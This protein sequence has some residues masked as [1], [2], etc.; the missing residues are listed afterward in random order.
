METRCTVIMPLYNKEEYISQAIDSVIAQR[1][2]FPIKLVIADD[3]STDSSL[4]IAKKY[5]AE[6]P[7]LITVLESD[8]NR[9][10]L[11]NDIRVYE[12]M[13]TDY[14]CVLDP[15]DFWVDEQFIQKAV[16]FLDANKD[17]VCYSS[18]SILVEPGKEERAYIGA[19][20]KEYT[21]ASVYDYLYDNAIIPHTTGSVYRNSIF[22]KGVPDIIKNA[23]GTVSEASFRGDHDRF[24]IHLKYGKSYF[25]NEFVGVYRINSTGIWS[26]S[27]Q[28]HRDLLDVRA[29]MDYCAFY[30]NENEDKFREIARPYWRNVLL[31]TEEYKKRGIELDKQ[32]EEI[33]ESVKDWMEKQ[34]VV[35]FCIGSYQRKDT[36]LELVNH[37]LSCKRKDI[38]VVVVDNHSEDGLMDALSEIKD[39]R[40]RF[41]EHEATTNCKVTWYDAMAC[42]TG[43]WLFQVNDRD[44]I[45][46]DYMDKLIDTLSLFATTNVSFAVA[47]EEITDERDYSVYKEGKDTHAQFSLRDSHPTGQIIRKIYWDLCDD[48][49]KYYFE[50]E[51]GIYPHGYLY[52]ELGN[53][54]KGAYIHFD[55][56]DMANYDKRYAATSSSKVY[57]ASEKGTEWFMPSSRYN[58]LERAA[59]YSYLL[60]N[61]EDVAN[62]ILNRYVRFFT[63]S[64]Y[65]FWETCHDEQ[66]KRR[67]DRYD[68]ETNYLSILA[69]GYD[70]SLSFRTFLEN[71]DFEWA[72]KNF[73]DS[74]NRY[75]ASLIA[76][77]QKWATQKKE[78]ENS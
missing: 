58:L 49:E 40:L 26:S 48:K 41:F 46:L 7:K 18:N 9:G 19:S 47:G 69:N 68:L 4:S 3:C 73:Y 5:E 77:L 1:T 44:W 57:K 78:E 38:E 33:Y 22:S 42:A 28:I 15:D 76:E 10:L 17:Y 71:N 43:Q 75:D 30:D 45:N 2:T 24:V 23:V 16:T 27:K 6:N 53:I 56:T 36:T 14:F 65:G 34:P 66:L 12:T 63:F 74:L 35:S 67:Y 8:K 31:Q 51:Y 29:K 52:A 39:S 62:M 50:D 25:L 11:S 59:E 54:S 32:D 20:V 55:I 64:T 37:I 21:T 13:K 61:Q 70:F 60:N 72:D